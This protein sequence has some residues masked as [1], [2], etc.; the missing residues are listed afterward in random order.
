M[1]SEFMLLPLLMLVLVP[2]MGVPLARWL[3]DRDRRVA[4]R[5]VI[6]EGNILVGL[7]F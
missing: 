7:F 3:R 5:V 4:K 6:L 2:V 1:R